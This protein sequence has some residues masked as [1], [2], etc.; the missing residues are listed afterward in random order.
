MWAE[1]VSLRLD[2]LSKSSTFASIDVTH[3]IGE[4]A[5]PYSR[6]NIFIYVVIDSLGQYDGY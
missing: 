1:P 4:I 2:A 6:N 3:A 5:L